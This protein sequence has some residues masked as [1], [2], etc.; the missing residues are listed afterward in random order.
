MIS[1]SCG[2]DLVGLHSLFGL[3]SLHVF[4]HV[5]PK[6]MMFCFA[7]WCNPDSSQAGS[8][9]R[10]TVN[11][12][13]HLNIPITSPWRVSSLIVHRIQIVFPPLSLIVFLGRYSHW[14]VSGWDLLEALSLI[15][16]SALFRS[17]YDTI[18][19]DKKWSVPLDAEQAVHRQGDIPGGSRSP[20]LRLLQQ[21]QF[22]RQYRHLAGC[23]DGLCKTELRQSA[24][25][26]TSPSE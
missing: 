21:A 24:D 11:T 4:P 16:L 1:P 17:V 22:R 20:A 15:H 3:N 6:M 10:W 13:C 8:S 2:S 25:R 14:T 18:H 23:R 26:H 9:L 19:M 5:L 12:Y 7:L